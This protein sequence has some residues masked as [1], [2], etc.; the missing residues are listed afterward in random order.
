V[1]SSRK[2]LD[3]TTYRVQ[4]LA[5]DPRWLR[6]APAAFERTGIRRMLAQ[7]I[8][9]DGDTLGALNLDATRPAAFGQR[10]EGMGKVFA[11][12]A[13]LGMQAVRAQDRAH[14]LAIA[15]E[16][17]R[18]IGTAVGIL[19]ARHRWLESDAFEALRQHSQDHNL[20]LADISERVILT[21]ELSTD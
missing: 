20:R 13:A 15:L 5:E 19:M 21:G 17:N 16:S 9:V 11:T 4:D 10:E 12:P 3:A 6:F 14:R 2:R 8:F 1:S 7:R 18:R